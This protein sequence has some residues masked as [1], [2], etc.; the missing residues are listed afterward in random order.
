L[1]VSLQPTE[2]SRLLNWLVSLEQQGVR[3]DEAGLERAEKGLVTTRL[4][5]RA[6]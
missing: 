2:F 6:G 3:V 4:L 5:L 1:Q